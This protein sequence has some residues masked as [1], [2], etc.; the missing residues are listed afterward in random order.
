M[1]ISLVVNHNCNLRCSYCYT[2]RKTDRPM[3]VE[4]ARK[5]VDFGLGQVRGPRV[6]FS[7]F[8]GEPLLESDLIDEVA[9]FARTEADRRE[10]AIA[11]QFSTNGSLIDDNTIDLLKKHNFRLQVSYDG[12]P[13]A[14]DATR[15][16]QNGHSSNGL[17]KAGLKRLLEEKRCE[18]VVSVVDPKN[19]QFLPESYAHLCELG[20][21]RWVLSPNYA[22]NWDQKACDTLETAIAE[23]ADCYADGFRRGASMQVENIN[24][25][26]LT[27]VQSVY[28]DRNMCSMGK[29]EMAIAPSGRIY[30]CDRMVCEDNDLDLCIG[31]VDDGIDVEKRD[32]L[33]AAARM[34]DDECR[35]C[36]D[37]G[38]CMHW[39]GCVNSET[40]GHP[41]KV[42]P[43][44][45]WIQRCFIQ[46][47]DRMAGEL[48]A[49]KNPSFLKTFYGRIRPTKRLN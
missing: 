27:H 13:Q 23:L 15:R 28:T 24:A 37:R 34:G 11:F 7:F 4:M 41:G 16:F 32:S 38:R 17:V 26:V 48:F 25:K 45:C 39:C 33:L 35:S 42:S 29:R 49:E 44:V 30:P 5:A 6:C 18:Q 43:V 10:I 2:G 31:H 46:A 40:T 14:Q 1:K 21:P 20:V 9:A 3:S 8:G 47:T 12:C 36:E 22:G 19:A